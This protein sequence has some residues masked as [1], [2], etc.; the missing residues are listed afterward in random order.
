MGEFQSVLVGNFLKVVAT[1]HASLGYKLSE[2]M[3][4]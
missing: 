2:Y 4:T 3:R 1:L